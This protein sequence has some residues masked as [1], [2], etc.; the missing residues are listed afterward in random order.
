MKT[1]PKLA[2]AALSALTLGSI[3]VAFASDD[4]AHHLKH[5]AQLTQT[6]LAKKLDL[7]TEESAIQIALKTAPGVVHEIE[8]DDRKY[9]RGWKYEIE[10]LDA[11]GS[12][13]EVDIDA[14]TGEVL[15]SKKER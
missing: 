4:S 3:G 2:I 13:W 14:K 15:K 9:G 8:L 1:F 10:I 5:A 7:I 12:E 6:E 11:N